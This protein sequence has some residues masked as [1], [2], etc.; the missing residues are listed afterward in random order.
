MCGMNNFSFLV[1]FL[2][3]FDT[4][5]I[6]IYIIRN[7]YFISIHCDLFFY[8]NIS[9]ASFCSFIYLLMHSELVCL[10]R[11]IIFI[12]SLIRFVYFFLFSTLL[13]FIVLCNYSCSPIGVLSHTHSIACFWFN[14]ICFYLFIIIIIIVIVRLQ[15]VFEFFRFE[16]QVFIVYIAC[17][18]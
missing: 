7:I 12:L 6:Y 15:S 16:I 10:L 5:I 14:F 11:F 13:W 8:S 2:D 4:V 9:F 1:L 3:E 17:S 18:F